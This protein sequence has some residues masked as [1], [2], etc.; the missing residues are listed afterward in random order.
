MGALTDVHPFGY[1]EALEVLVV[2]LARLASEEGTV[3][4]PTLM[5]ELLLDADELDPQPA[6][7]RASSAAR[8]TAAKR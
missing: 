4:A 6:T 7:A 1:C 3:V 5:A 2:P 8:P